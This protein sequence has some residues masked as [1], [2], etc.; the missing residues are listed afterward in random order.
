MFRVILQTLLFFALVACASVSKNS[1]SSPQLKKTAANPFD[2]LV[3]NPFV[4]GVF[5]LL[6]GTVDLAERGSSYVL[7][8]QD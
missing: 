2:A 1:V 6:K 5:Y 4:D 7:G 8:A 3:E